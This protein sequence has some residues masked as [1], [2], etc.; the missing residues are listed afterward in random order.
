MVFISNMCIY[1]QPCK[2]YCIIG[3]IACINLWLITR[4]Q[5]PHFKQETPKKV[6]SQFTN[7][8]VKPTN[9]RFYSS[10]QIS[11]EVQTKDS[12]L[13]KHTQDIIDVFN[14]ELVDV[15]LGR[16]DDSRKYKLFDNVIIGNNY[17]NLSI[18]YDV[19]LATQSSLDKLHWLTDIVR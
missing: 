10:I 9:Q 5:L 19:T 2:C 6:K 18:E 12:V 13:Q 3:L 1:K 7:V 11:T 15:N 8:V 4:I 16:F 14:S 17:V